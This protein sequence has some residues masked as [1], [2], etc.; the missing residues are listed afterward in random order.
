MQH[1]FPKFKI[2]KLKSI[3]RVPAELNNI[4]DFLKKQKK[5]MVF[6]K[7]LIRTRYRRDCSLRRT[8]TVAQSASTCLK[9]CWVMRIAQTLRLRSSRVI[10]AR[11][12]R[13][14]AK[15]PAPCS[16]FQR[17]R[18]RYTEIVLLPLWRFAKSVH[19]T[20][21]SH[22]AARLTIHLLWRKISWVAPPRC[23]WLRRHYWGILREEK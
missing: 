20:P 19:I 4:V 17:E 11:C 23:T 6:P 16:F 21:V 1:V 5:S 15:L 10:A 8:S 22:Q 14:T 13:P 18:W 9:T 7:G 2:W 12:H 3:N